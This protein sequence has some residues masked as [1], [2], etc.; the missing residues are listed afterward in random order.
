KRLISLGED[1][2]I[3]VWDVTVGEAIATAP[4][5]KMGGHDML[6][7]NLASVAASPDGQT[8]VVA[9]PDRSTRLL[10]STG[11][12]LRRLPTSDPEVALAFSPDGKCLFTGGPLIRAW[13]VATGKE[14]PL[15]DE[16]RDPIRALSLSPDGK[17][18]A[19]ADPDGRL[20]LADVA[21]GKTL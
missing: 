13:D 17:T 9:L 8:L 4:V 19:L 1:G 7:G 20:R 16:P 12:E 11:R 10:D 21:T 14:I 3:R 6:R 15:L 2:T 5:P 18:A